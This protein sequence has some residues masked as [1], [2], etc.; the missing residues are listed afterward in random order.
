MEP[1]VE[2]FLST[3]KA[4]QGISLNTLLAY[5]ADLQQFGRIVNAASPSA[6]GDERLTLEA[7]RTYVEWLSGQSYKA[8]TVA[9]K[10]AAVR[11]YLRSRTYSSSPELLAPLK[12]P[13]TEPSGTQILTRSEIDRLLSAPVARGRARDLRDAAILAILYYTGL[14]ASDAVGLQIGDVDL[15]AGVVTSRR[16]DSS[17]SLAGALGPVRLYIER[18]RLG[19]ETGSEP[20]ALFLN[21]RGGVLSRQGLWL[22]VKRWARSGGLGSRISPHT[23]RL[24][25]AAHLLDQGV[26]AREIRSFLGL[27]RAHGLRLPQRGESLEGGTVP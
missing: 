19:V 16:I 12:P 15:S 3:L 4:R 10:M 13:P 5:R 11:G 7:V 25:R 17:R 6:Q 8:S 2:E 14:R 20:R 18:T 27:S 23:L 24:S 26:P 22:V 1:D 9:R 21:Q